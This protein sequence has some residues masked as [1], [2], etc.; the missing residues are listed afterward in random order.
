MRSPSRIETR[1]SLLPL[2]AK[3]TIADFVRQM[4]VDPHPVCTLLRK[5]KWVS[6]PGTLFSAASKCLSSATSSKPFPAAGIAPL[7]GACLCFLFSIKGRQSLE[8]ETDNGL[9]IDAYSIKLGS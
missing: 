3:S 2:I 5:E 1:L 9:E 4:H 8:T 6:V 7:P